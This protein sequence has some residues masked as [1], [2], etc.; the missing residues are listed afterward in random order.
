MAGS[1]K[2]SKQLVS[3]GNDFTVLAGKAL[4]P[5]EGFEHGGVEF[6]MFGGAEQKALLIARPFDLSNQRAGLPAFSFSFSSP[7]TNPTGSR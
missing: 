7:V 3:L 4:T 2:A 1:P 6:G 5:R